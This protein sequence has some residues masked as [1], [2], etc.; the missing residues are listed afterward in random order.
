M[1]GMV[2]LKHTYRLS[3]EEVWD[4]WVHD[5]YFQYFTGEEFFDASV[6]FGLNTRCPM[7]GPA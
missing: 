5:P 3:D 7:S 1:L 2:M 6:P 4:R